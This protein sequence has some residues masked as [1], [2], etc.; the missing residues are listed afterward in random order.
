LLQA[1]KQMKCK[2][3][4]KK[5]SLQKKSCSRKT[6]SSASTAQASQC[7]RPS[8]TA[9]L[10]NVISLRVARL[11][12]VAR[13]ESVA[14][15]FAK[16][17]G[18]LKRNKPSRL[19]RRLLSCPDH[20]ACIPVDTGSIYTVVT[21]DYRSVVTWIAQSIGATRAPSPASRAAAQHRVYVGLTSHRAGR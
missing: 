3:N 14:V 9:D 13:G 6:L 7:F 20:T 21:F 12:P 2:R 1:V 4:K 16:C 17:S 10:K 15:I 18:L 5:K 11:R 8:P 19:L